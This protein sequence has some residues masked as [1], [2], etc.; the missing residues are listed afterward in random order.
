MHGRPTTLP[1]RRVLFCGRSCAACVV[2]HT[3]VRYKDVPGERRS[4]LVLR[5]LAS[6][7]MMPHDAHPRLLFTRRE[8]IQF[9]VGGLLMPFAALLSFSGCTSPAIRSQSPEEGD[10]ANS[11]S[12]IE[13]IGNVASPYGLQYVTVEGP[14]LVTGLKDTGSDPPPSAA[15]TTLLG[16]MQ[17]RGVVNIKK[18]LSSPTTSLVWVRAYLPPGVQKGDSLDIE[19]RVPPN[20]DTTDLS[21]GWVM[22]TRL[23]EKAVIHNTLRDGHEWAVVQGPILVDPL[24]QK[25]QDRSALTRG[26][27]LSG[28][29]CAQ[30]SQFMADFASR[31][32]IGVRKQAG[33]RC[34]QSP[35]SYLF[36]R[37]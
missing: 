34:P 32:K 3:L 5:T 31:Q 11:D 21:G 7:G 27:V 35:F 20:N 36:A 30:I 17:A 37:Q 18:I 6:E 33:G 22:E 13:L 12:Q 8:L 14:A 24:I 1:A 25:E 15:R 16:E 9:G 10:L 28:A 2:R 4:G 26:R 19:V 29:L 23:R